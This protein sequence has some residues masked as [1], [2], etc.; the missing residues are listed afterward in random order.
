M[1]GEPSNLGTL[2]EIL[3]CLVSNQRGL[4]LFYKAKMHSS[5]DFMFKCY[6]MLIDALYYCYSDFVDVGV[7]EEEKKNVKR[8]TN[9]V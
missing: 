8:N 3:Q 6:M 5:N 9:T 1:P 7:I 2:K 4:N